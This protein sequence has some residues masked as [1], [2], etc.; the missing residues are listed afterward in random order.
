MERLRAKTCGQMT[1]EIYG[2]NLRIRNKN[3]LQRLT[4]KRKVLQKT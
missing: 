3:T 4:S 1:G 2:P